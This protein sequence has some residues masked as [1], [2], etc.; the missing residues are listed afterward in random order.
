MAKW[1]REMA[2]WKEQQGMWLHEFNQWK[3]ATGMGGG[4]YHMDD[5][6]YYEEEHHYDEEHHYEDDHND[7][8][9]FG[10]FWN[11]IAPMMDP[12]MMCPM[13]NMIIDE[14]WGL[15]SG[16]DWEAG[17]RDQ[18]KTQM[19]FTELFENMWMWDSPTFAK[20][21]CYQVGTTMMGAF[22]MS[23]IGEMAN[24]FV[25]H[26][27]PMCNCVVHNIVDISEGKFDLSNMGSLMECAG[28]VAAYVEGAI[29][30]FYGWPMPNMDHDDKWVDK[31]DYSEANVSKVVMEI[32]EQFSSIEFNEDQIALMTIADNTGDMYDMINSDDRNMNMAAVAMMVI[33]NDANMEHGNMGGYSAAD[34]IFGMLEQ[35]G[36]FVQFYENN[37]RMW[38]AL[39]GMPEASMK[40]LMEMGIEKY[41]QILG[42]PFESR[43]W[44]NENLPGADDADFVAK[45]NFF[46]SKHGADDGFAA[47]WDAVYNQEKEDM[48]LAP[49]VA[50]QNWW[51]ENMWSD[52][53]PYHPHHVL[54]VAKCLPVEKITEWA[55]A[56][57]ETIKS[58]IETMGEEDAEFGACMMPF[59][60][61]IHDEYMD[62]GDYSDENTGK[63]MEEIRSMFADL[64]FNE[65]QMRLMGLWDQSGEWQNNGVF[66]GDREKMLWAMATTVIWTEA[67]D[68]EFMAP[69]KDVRETVVW[70]MENAEAWA[71]FYTNNI[72][73]MIDTVPDLAGMSFEDLKA[74][75]PEKWVSFMGDPREVVMWMHAELPDPE[76]D[77]FDDF[78]EK[79]N[80]LAGGRDD[81]G[82]V[83]EAAYNADKEW[84]IQALVDLQNY[85]N[86]HMQNESKPVLPQT[87]MGIAA[88]LNIDNVRDW[89]N[90]GASAAQV[91]AAIT[92]E[93]MNASGDFMQ[94]FS[95]GKFTMES[96]MEA[97]K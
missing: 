1:R 2:M 42:D 49:F 27:E 75:G 92:G 37:M 57:H 41:G 51:L 69:G 94:C 70:M 39:N 59:A 95:K 22:D 40:D 68:E 89:M 6:H 34:M 84:D 19:A 60:K 87:V 85:Y 55:D 76:G 11:M 47:V 45:I 81:F 66:D 35:A 18:M 64:E 28:S 93:F 7:M 46:A 61:D 10:E 20:K 21:F 30:G 52:E 17:C 63:V 12:D 44:M 65:Q 31:G 83:Y 97:M 38:K 62:M 90:S 5:G 86:D 71:D 91:E 82:M 33:W 54:G 16:A 43:W 74:M 9:A 48:S 26:A 50:M 3:M 78:V 77:D 73:W 25:M 15:G 53:E 56:D 23:G 8:D 67:N 72:N 14:S 36:D 88:C 79:A 24:P 4:D 58:A 96:M 32:Y 80:Y 13:F 29:T